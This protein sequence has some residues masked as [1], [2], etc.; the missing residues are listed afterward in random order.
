M[1]TSSHAPIVPPLRVRRATRLDVD[2]LPEWTRAFALLRG[3]NPVPATADAHPGAPATDSYVVLRD[4]LRIAYVECVRPTEG[5]LEFRI[6][7]KP[8]AW[9]LVSRADIIAAVTPHL[10]TRAGTSTTKPVA[11]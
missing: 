1:S 7:L 4:A 10:E 2:A 11:A 6:F 5:T 3:L 8:A 9:A